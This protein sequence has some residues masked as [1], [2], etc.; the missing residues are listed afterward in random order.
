MTFKDCQPLTLGY[1][2]PAQLHPFDPKNH[3]R[4]SSEPLENSLRSAQKS[5]ECCQQNERKQFELTFQIWRLGIFS[6]L[7]EYKQ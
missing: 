5:M 2:T 1:C 6:R 4:E 3:T 7:M